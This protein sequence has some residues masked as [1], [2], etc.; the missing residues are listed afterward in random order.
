MRHKLVYV[1]EDFPEDTEDVVYIAAKVNS[2]WYRRKIRYL[3]PPYGS[4]EY[5][6]WER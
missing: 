2:I 5:Q 1:G 3:V 4:Y 6:G